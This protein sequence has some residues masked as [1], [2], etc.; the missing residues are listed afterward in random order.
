MKKIPSIRREYGNVELRKK[1]LLPDPFAQ[2]ELWFEDAMAADIL[3]V[4]AMVLATVDEKGLPD[5]RVVLLKEFDEQ[6]FVFF[7]DYDSPKS[8]QAEKS[9]V[10]ALNFHWPALARQVR[11]KGGIVRVSRQD[12]E[13]YFS[14]RPRES[15]ISTL[16]S[17]QSHVIASREELENH[18]KETA[19]AYTGKEIPCPE[20]WGGYCVIPLEFE[21]FQG[22]D[23]RLNDRIRYLKLNNH[24]QI[25]RLSP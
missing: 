10:V 23:N 18:F 15:Q 3:D 24:W 21:F 14:S 2:F 9:G 17:K 19:Q 12:S 16:I 4:T 8:I 7:T 20:H 25:E 1:N 6:G 5:A 11:I 13:R 22:R